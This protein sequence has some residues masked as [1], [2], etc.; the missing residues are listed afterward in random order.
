MNYYRIKE[1]IRDKLINKRS[2]V[3]VI[4]YSA[5]RLMLHIVYGEYGIFRMRFILDKFR[6]E[7]GHKSYFDKIKNFQNKYKGKRCFIVATGPSLTLED[8]NKLND[9]KEYTFGMNSLVGFFDKTE[10][11]PN[12]YVLQDCDVYKKNKEQIKK[13]DD[14]SSVYFFFFFV[15]S[16]SPYF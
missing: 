13:Y 4:A 3:Y 8:L 10:W 2:A 11:R 12:F 16:Y 6:R 1:S 15:K 14:A 5:H 7:K 9:Y